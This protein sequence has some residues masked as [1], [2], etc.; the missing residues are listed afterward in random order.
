L[1]AL[2][3]G[4]GISWD[5]MSI[6][7]KKRGER[8]WGA[9]GGNG[10]VGLVRGGVFRKK[11]EFGGAYGGKRPGIRQKDGNKGLLPGRGGGLSGKK[12]RGY[13]SRSSFHKHKLPT[14]ISNAPQR[15]KSYKKLWGITKH[16]GRRDGERKKRKVSLFDRRVGGG[17]DGQSVS[18]RRRQPSYRSKPPQRIR[19]SSHGGRKLQ[20]SICSEKHAMGSRRDVQ[21]RDPLR[22]EPGSASREGGSCIPRLG[23]I[24][25]EKKGTGL[26]SNWPAIPRAAGKTNFPRTRRNTGTLTKGGKK[27]E[28]RPAK[29]NGR[30]SGNGGDGVKGK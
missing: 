7:K 9:V 25:E 28:R 29:T 19:R 22:T 24:G 1:G 18:R 17:R 14:R 8:I 12:K 13:Q 5:C 10:W 11:V 15:Q 4:E 21:L 30:K 20:A 2:T 26:P 23:E 3:R 6:W 27:G 16:R